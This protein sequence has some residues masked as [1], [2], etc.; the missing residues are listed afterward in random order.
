MLINSFDT[1]AQLTQELDHRTP[2][3]ALKVGHVGTERPAHRTEAGHLQAARL[4]DQDTVDGVPGKIIL[5]LFEKPET[6]RL[7]IK[8]GDLVMPAMTVHHARLRVTKRIPAWHKRWAVMAGITRS[9]AL[10]TS[11]FVSGFSK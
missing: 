10:I 11:R 2:S 5:D 4:V 8:A 7:V 9:P 3:K 1:R 6:K